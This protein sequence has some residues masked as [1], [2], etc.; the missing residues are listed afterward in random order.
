MYRVINDIASV[1][2]SDLFVAMDWAQRLYWITAEPVE[3]FAP[4]G[5]LIHTVSLSL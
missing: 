1:G 4:D 3:V 5:A 2:S